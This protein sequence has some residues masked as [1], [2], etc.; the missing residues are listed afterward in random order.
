MGYDVHITRRVE[1]SDENGSRITED[2]WQKYVASD[3][4]LVITGFAE[5]KTPS[6]EIIRINRPLL[7]EW[8]R[9]TKQSLVWLS[10]CDGNI[11]IKNPDEEC[12]A[13]LRQIA[14]KLQARVQ[15][16]EGEYYDE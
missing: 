16:D 5:L 3:P 8:R 2:D 14:S 9:P 10:Y 11:S 7:T 13:K 6:G 4:E 12:L 15:G 1:W